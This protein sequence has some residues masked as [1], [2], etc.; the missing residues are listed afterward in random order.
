MGMESNKD[1]KIVHLLENINEKLGE[2][3]EKVDS[4]T[5]KEELREYKEH[6]ADAETRLK[7]GFQF[8]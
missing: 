1:K 8:K 3:S 4:A 5:L 2:V 7:K 6:F